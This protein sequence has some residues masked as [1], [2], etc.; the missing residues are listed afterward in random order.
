MTRYSSDDARERLVQSVHDALDAADPDPARLASIRAHLSSAPVRGGTTLRE[1]PGR[2]PWWIACT[3]AGA[4]AALILM[5]V[6]PAVDRQTT[7]SAA[8]ILGRSRAA[9]SSPASGIEVLTYDLSVDG[10]LADLL[11][12]EQTGRFTVEETTDHDRPGRYRLLKLAPGGDIVA[13][14]ADDPVR[15]M[16]V[17]Y[18]RAHGRGYLLRFADANV[19]AFPLP[20]VKRMALQAF[21][22]LMQTG[23]DQAVRE[24]TCDGEACY[25]VIV[26]QA[27]HAAGGIVSLSHARALITAADARIVEFSAT[28]QIAERPFGIEFVLRNRIVRAE[29]A[30]DQ[31]AFDI[32]PRPGDV[33]LQ[34]NA[35]SNPMW[36]V[37]ERALAA[38]PQQP[39]R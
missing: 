24:T 38:I 17:R 28:G 3:V 9:L 4:V 23:D 31:S 10:V 22:T 25:E 8:E 32:T 37:I 12:S 18:L 20:A 35:S 29:T 36:D 14:I 26:P 7:V 2:S 34:G 15:G 30:A 27:A 39:S 13:G 19:A 16:R 6:L 5:V 11:P 33:V 21:I 1:R